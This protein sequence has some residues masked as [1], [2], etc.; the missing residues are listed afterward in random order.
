MATVHPRLGTL[1]P[2]FRDEV[3]E[4]HR[5]GSEALALCT[6]PCPFL[7]SVFC[8]PLVTSSSPSGTNSATPWRQGGRE[9]RPEPGWATAAACPRTVP[10][11]TQ[12]I[13][14]RGRW[15]LGSQRG[16]ACGAWGHLTCTRTAPLSHLMSSMPLQPGGLTPRPREAEPSPFSG[17]LPTPLPPPNPPPSTWAQPSREPGQG[18]L[19]RGP[20][21]ALHC[22]TQAP[23]PLAHRLAATPSSGSH[24]VAAFSLFLE[25]QPALHTLPSSGLR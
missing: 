1:H 12:N 15:V 25:S 2:H 4:A 9:G 6:G 24:L 17:S 18:R 13:T 5:A 3:T 14:G 21:R 7:A 10:T 11:E 8:L 20:G 16:G 23:G 22:P 19:G